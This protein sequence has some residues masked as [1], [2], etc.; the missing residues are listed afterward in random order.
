MSLK[1]NPEI[2]NATTLPAEFYI[3]HKYFDSSIKNIFSYSWQ[4]ITDY[5]TL[6][7]NN[8]YPFIFLENSVNEPLVL[9]KSDYK[10]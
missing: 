7:H 2:S 10:I 9:I 8:I 5:D 1:I 4:L 3:D 6:N